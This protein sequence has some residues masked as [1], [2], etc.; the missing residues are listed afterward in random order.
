MWRSNFPQNS[1]TNRVVL[2][3]VSSIYRFRNED[4]CSFSVLYSNQN[5]SETF[6]WIG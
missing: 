1:A 4:I 5:I 2:A 3:P 6:G